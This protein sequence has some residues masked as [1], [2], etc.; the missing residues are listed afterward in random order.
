MGNITN[1]FD[2]NV[3]SS[4]L[5]H[6]MNKNGLKNKDL[7]SLL[8][9]SKSAISNYIAGISIP[10]TE[11]L[12]KIAETFG[13]PIETLIKKLPE[14]YVLE[15]NDYEVYRV[16]LFADTLLS[17]D[18]VYRNDHFNGSLTFPFPIYGDAECYAVKMSDNGLAS[19]GIMKKSIVIFAADV[20]VK[21]GELAA[22]LNK[23][24]LK[25]VIRR[26]LIDKNYITVSDDK[27]SEVYQYQG[28]SDEIVILGKVVFATFAPN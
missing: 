20:E 19:S 12:S 2:K 22:I 7:A 21:N 3:F 13:V 23:N 11:V 1:D 6:L 27:K 26:V 24:K 14:A 4:N 25:I 8:G 16:P 9:L 17:A 10:R 18:M 15:E 28:K 5:K